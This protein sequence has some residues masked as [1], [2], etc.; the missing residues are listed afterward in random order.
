MPLRG[1]CENNSS[2]EDEDSS[3]DGN[4]WKRK[5]SNDWSPHETLKGKSIIVADFVRELLNFLN[6]DFALV[7]FR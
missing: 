6:R 4:D 7:V 2:D 3:D 1:S 5:K